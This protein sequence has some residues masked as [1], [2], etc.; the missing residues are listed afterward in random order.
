LSVNQSDRL[1]ELINTE[2]MI[3]LIVMFRATSLLT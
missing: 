3:F 2:D 1:D